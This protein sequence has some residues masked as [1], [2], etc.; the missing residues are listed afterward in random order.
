F[1]DAAMAPQHRA[2]IVA[3]APVL[4]R[5]AD[6]LAAA[7]PSLAALRLWLLLHHATG[8]PVFATRVA[9]AYDRLGAPQ[10]AV[11]WLARSDVP[12]A[13]LPE[14]L[15]GARSDAQAQAADETR[16]LQRNLERVRARF[17]AAADALAAADDTGL[18]VLAS[19]ELAWRWTTRHGCRRDGYPFVVRIDACEGGERVIAL[20]HPEPPAALRAQ[21]LANVQANARHAIVGLRAWASVLLLVSNR[22]ITTVP[23]WSQQ[24]YGVESEPAVLRRLLR[25]VD[26]GPVLDAGF[27]AQ[28]FVGDDAD[29]Q[30]LAFFEHHRLRPVP[31][32]RS[33]CPPALVE[34]FAR[35][36]AA[37]IDGWREATA[38]LA[39]R[40]DPVRLAGTLARLDAGAPLRVWLWTSIHTTVLRH[41]GVGL[42]AGFEAEGHDVR[43]TMER[44]P[45]D[46]YDLPAVARELLDAEPD[47]ALQIDHLRPEYGALLPP[48]LPVASWILDELPPLA[49]RAI[50]ARLGTLDLS[51]AWS[52]S[53]AQRYAALGHPHCSA[54]PFAVDPAIYHADDPVPATAAVAYATHLA[55]PIEPRFAPGL[56]AALE[57]RLAALPVLPQGHDELA[58]VLAA[59]LRDTGVV[60]PA[61][62]QASFAYDALLLARHV[63][64]VRVADE[65]LDAGVPL[66]LYGRGWAE[67]PRFAPHARG[68]VAPGP[69]LREM[70][71]RHKVVL[72]I[73]TRCNL[74]PR[75]L[76]A[77]ASGGFVLARSDGDYDHAPGGV[78]EALE[79]DRE[80]C[81]FVD[82]DDMLA[83]I[84]RALD[85]EPW[86]QGFVRAGA[87]R[88]HADH[89]YRARAR[90]M[91]AALHQRLR[92]LRSATPRAA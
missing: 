52:L 51:F 13:A 67:I 88:V 72:H 84:R 91:V 22:I 83:K 69:A 82:R 28:W 47:L 46:A 16:L 77:M 33:A 68:E 56:Y 19:D 81:L 89:T 29:A 70:Y 31:R 30:A 66:S 35:L 3:A 6:A 24:L 90:T 79:P 37:R 39:R 59:L 11:R 65:L 40:Y 43:L 14:L 92:A 20:D 42:L 48:G 45:A 76:E 41:V 74:H 73:N 21:L 80:L 85:D 34:G 2:A 4:V 44:D 87:A 58:P 1:V 64:R 15:A 63:E 54:L 50:I 17:P 26:V 61:A 71:Q 10:H 36:D 60:V 25:S 7:G 78:A 86:R 75:V 53:L 8:A 18:S 9:I 23:N 49:D 57:Q 38:A 55:R 12:S 62:L 5:W 27:F 32:V